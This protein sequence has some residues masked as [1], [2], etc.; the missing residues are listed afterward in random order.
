MS[1]S[2]LA[3]RPRRSG[4]LSARLGLA[5]AL[6]LAALTGG[7]IQPLYG[8][9]TVSKTGGT[10]RNALRSIEFPE[11]KGL[12]G[13]HLRNELVF[14]TDGG[15][16]PDAPKTL[17]FEA[18]VTESIEVLTVDYING[19]ADSAVL[20]AKASWTVKKIGSNEVVASGSNFARAP[21][22]RSSQ[23]FATDAQ[24][25]A[26]KTLADIIKNQIAADLVTG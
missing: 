8:E 21:Y 25:R 10:V 3:M 20:V 6:S 12:I 9:Y 23:R 14:E 2:E 16:G 11:I 5:V 19:R 24:I 13:H 7:C 17:R 1:S 15:A 22:E 26:A 4:R 18:N